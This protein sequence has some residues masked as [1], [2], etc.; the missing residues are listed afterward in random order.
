MLAI[1]LLAMNLLVA[2]FWCVRVALERQQLMMK[3]AFALPQHI[4]RHQFQALPK[5][6]EKLRQKERYPGGQ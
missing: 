6:T 3:Q 4:R 1:F 2:Q 5:G